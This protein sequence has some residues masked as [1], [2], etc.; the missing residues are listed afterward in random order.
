MTAVGIMHPLPIYTTGEH[1]LPGNGEHEL[2][3]VNKKN[4]DFSQFQF[5]QFHCPVLQ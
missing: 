3:L 2:L 1:P 4:S 5:F